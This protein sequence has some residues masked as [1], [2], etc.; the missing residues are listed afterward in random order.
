MDV[1]SSPFRPADDIDIDLDSIR[2][3]SVVGS[4]HDEMIDD[5]TMPADADFDV[6]QD[7]FDEALVDDDMFDDTV[8]DAPA[9]H[10]IDYN[11]DGPGQELLAD[12]DDDILYEDE[13]IQPLPPQDG[14]TVE[15]NE[16]QAPQDYQETA[17]EALLEA[18]DHQPE[19]Q[20]QDATTTNES[21]TLL[22]AG[23][24][25]GVDI[26]DNLEQDQTL[27]TIQ[28]HTEE[29]DQEKTE[30]DGPAEYLDPPEHTGYDEQFS[31]HQ[32]DI[33][34]T[35]DGQANAEVAPVDKETTEA[36]HEDL[37]AIDTATKIIHPVTIEYLEDEMSLFPP[38]LGDASSMYFLSDS[39]LA[40]EPVDQLL[41]ACRD[42]LGETLDHHDELVLDV[43]SLGLH[44]CEDSKY[45]AQ[46]TMTQILD[47]YLHLCHNDEGQ[48]VQPLYCQLSS[49]VSLATQYAYLASAGGEGKTYGEIA[50]DHLDSPEPDEDLAKAVN[51]IQGQHDGSQLRS[52][53]EATAGEQADDRQTTDETQD[54]QH[55]D[56][57]NLEDPMQSNLVTEVAPHLA[58]SHAVDTGVDLLAFEPDSVDL[59]TANEAAEQLG[60]HDQD[61]PQGNSPGNEQESD[62]NQPQVAV[63]ASE[64]DQVAEDDTSSSHT[65][66]GDQDDVAPEPLSGEIPDTENDD[67]FESNE[68]GEDLFH[69]D[70]QVAEVQTDY[71]PFGDEE[72]FI[73]Q[74]DND[75]AFEQD[76]PADLEATEESTTFPDDTE[77]NLSQDLTSIPGHDHLAGQ[78]KS[79]AASVADALNSGNLS[80]PLTPEPGKQSKRKVEDDDEFLFLDLDTSDPKRRRAS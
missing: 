37:A 10:D 15:Y 54:G 40:S 78:P 11:M 68:L 56:I 39:S 25:T 36:Q 32:N 70:D 8:Q 58:D 34:E 79:P 4:V 5:P 1:A 67:L 20:E 26:A 35:E 52:E 73:A 43:P 71:E 23:T 44:I 69:E 3:P 76:L 74:D 31:E 57:D 64:T 59:S 27:D 33:Q 6:M 12:E 42:I 45:A 66:E 65:V 50:A 63:F 2:D 16:N 14:G 55:L 60:S 18:L 17:A 21:E 29:Q 49:R 77:Q 48:E 24:V 62:Y 51:D 46:I 13:E 75:Q 47:V 30:G 19:P 38:M 61:D 53:G 80:P 28:D 72:L 7:H 9:Q 22:L 41:A